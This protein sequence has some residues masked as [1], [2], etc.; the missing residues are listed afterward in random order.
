MGYSARVVLDSISPNGHRLTTLEVTFPRFILAEMNTHRVFCLAGDAK[1]EFELP[2]GA[3]NG[4]QRKVHYMTI[5][6]FVDKWVDG[7]ASRSSK[8]RKCF[9]RSHIDPTAEYSGRAAAALTNQAV[10]N[11]NAACRSGAIS[12]YK[13]IDKRQWIIRGSAL[14]AWLDRPSTN[15]QPIAGRL[16]EMRIRQ[17]DEATG[18]VRLATVAN[19]YRSGEKHVFEVEA[20]GGYRIAGS[21][22]HRVL[23]SEGW[24]TIG[25]LTPDDSLVVQRRGKPK[26]DR[27]GDRFKTV[28]GRWRSV[29]QREQLAIELS[30]DP[31]CRAC[32]ENPL[33]EIHH[34]IPVHERPDLAYDTD[35]IKAICGDCHTKY[36]RKQGWQTGVPLYAGTAR[37]KS[38]TLRGI[39]P[40]YDL[41]ISGPFP[42][43]FANKVVVH[44]SRNSAS[45]RAVP[46]K[47]MIERVKTDPVFPIE[48]GSNKAGMQAGEPLAELDA[49]N[50]ESLWKRAKDN[51]IDSAEVLAETGVHKQIV[52]RLLEPFLWH[53]AL[54][55]STEWKNF[56]EQRCSPMAQPEMR[57][58]AELMRSAFESSM[59]QKIQYERWHL[60]LVASMTHDG[61]DIVTAIKIS[62]ARCARVSYLNHDGKCDPAKDL[63]LY[64]KL[65][66]GKHLSPFEHVARPSDGSTELG[67]D[68]GYDEANFT[69]WRQARW[70]L[71]Q[72]L[73]ITA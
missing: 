3:K 11:I 41:S 19:A 9:D 69:G 10:T 29:W 62:V 23:T 67:E 43:F 31:I 49:F 18:E 12:A 72:G 28:G 33:T 6:E 14:L 73:E 13:W 39:E 16:G 21:K 46:I 32:L 52:N 48:W 8:P 40:T 55:T 1:L 53:T 20:E 38:V 7:S 15:R 54:I 37:V 17:V 30:M 58:T 44:N 51:A 34:I 66:G 2:A 59:P 65:V 42:N 22:D 68:Y 27:L 63:E 60:P 4:T 64:E 47:K 26:E 25:E 57:Y 56:F 71:E 45:S 50:A 5:S 24:K 61:M 36:H 70:N 35:N